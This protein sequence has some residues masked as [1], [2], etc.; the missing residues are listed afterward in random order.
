MFLALHRSGSIEMREVELVVVAVM[1]LQL[2]G[3]QVVLG[4]G[5][6]LVRSMTRLVTAKQTVI[7]NHTLLVK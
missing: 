2:L 4:F 6:E 3:H 7:I 1:V 5:I